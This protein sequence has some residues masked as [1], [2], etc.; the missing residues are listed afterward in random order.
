MGVRGTAGGPAGHGAGR[1][2]RADDSGRRDHRG[3]RYRRAWHGR[4]A[5]LTR[6]QGS[7][8]D[9][10]ADGAARHDAGRHATHPLEAAGRRAHRLT[11]FNMRMNDYMLWSVPDIE[12]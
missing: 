6:I 5:E 1:T 8:S 12:P 4:F 2:H 7:W 11:A 10:G 9:C 3:R